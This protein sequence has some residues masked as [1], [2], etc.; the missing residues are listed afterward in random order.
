MSVRARWSSPGAAVAVSVAVA[1]VWR[2]V[3][4]RALLGDPVYLA[5]VLDAAAHLSWARGILDG[6]WPPAE[7]FFRA[8]GYPYA[9]AF[10]LG[11]CGDDPSRAAVAQLLL[12]AVVPG[13]V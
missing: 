4:A 10:L 13:L 2:A 8:P 11:L 1:L 6:T 7:A 9:L 3:Y 5:P 12:G